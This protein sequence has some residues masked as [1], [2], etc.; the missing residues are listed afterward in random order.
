MD[1]V[2]PQHL[3]WEASR[4]LLEK[5]GGN[6]DEREVPEVD[7]VAAQDLT[8]EASRWLLEGSGGEND[9]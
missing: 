1:R 5:M 4:C 2:A 8:W 6:H 7:R 9:G 3:T